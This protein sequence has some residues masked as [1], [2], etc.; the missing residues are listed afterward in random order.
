M[1]SD[2]SE[3]RHDARK[4]INLPLDCRVPA[5]PLKAVLSNISRQG[6]AAEGVEPNLAKQGAT[7][8]LQLTDEAAVSGQVV[9]HKGNHI[10]VK[11]FEPLDDAM[12]AAVAE[13][14]RPKSAGKR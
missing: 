6:C 14:T 3:R 11:F 12:F 8:L 7:I 4:L 9:W 1:K 10:G 5:T 13:R 2:Q